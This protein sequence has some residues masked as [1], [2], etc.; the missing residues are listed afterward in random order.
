MQER[1]RILITQKVPE[2][3]Y[4]LLEEVGILDANRQEGLIWSP[5]EL[6]QHAPGHEY[7]FCLLTD[8]IDAQLL[9][10]CAMAKPRLKLVALMAVGFNNID[11]AERTMSASRRASSAEERS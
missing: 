3:A 6:L 4:S 9:E 5:Q 10:A 1:P 7:L 2:P 8:N 11:L